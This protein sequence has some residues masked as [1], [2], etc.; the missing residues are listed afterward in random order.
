M[1]IERKEILRDRAL[2][3]FI[4]ANS[5]CAFNSPEWFRVLEE[6]FGCAVTGYCFKK[7]SE[8]KAVLPG[9]ILD[10]RIIKIFYSNIPY[11]GFVGDSRP[12][13]EYIQLLEKHLIK[14]GIDVLRFTKRAGDSYSLPA[15]YK[16]QPGC[17]QVINI[18]G[19]TSKGL[20]D[21]YKKRVRRDIRKAERSGV[22]IK[23][24][25]ERTEIDKMYSLY[26]K[27][28]ER[29]RSYTV[30]TSKALYSIYDNLVLPGKATVLFADIAGETVAGIIL[31]Y[32]SDTV[33]Y[34]MNASLSDYLSYCPNDLLLQSTMTIGIEKKASFVDLMTSRDSDRELIRFKEKWG[35]EQMDFS[36]LEKDLN[37]FKASVWNLTW[38]LANTR[39]GTS[40][41]RMFKKT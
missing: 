15:G 27:T 41:I 7:G 4:A 37:F 1:Q 36:I 23:Q 22:T 3:D 20:W 32:S 35:A 6:G 19:L 10:F 38:K 29:N 16:I 40:L 13:G 28:M 33:Y 25:K 39:L 31:I 14:D 12:L 5:N 11:G 9:I 30:W 34:F 26:R 18:S 17:Q 24:I 8:L 21:G 2:I